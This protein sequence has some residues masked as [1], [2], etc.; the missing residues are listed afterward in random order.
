MTIGGIRTPSLGL[1]WVWT[2]AEWPQKHEKGA[3]APT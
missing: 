2:T 3:G 1:W